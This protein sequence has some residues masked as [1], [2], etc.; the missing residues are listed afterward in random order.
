M[1]KKLRVFKLRDSKDEELH[2]ELEEYKKEL[3]SLR[4]AKI[5]GGTAAKLGRIRVWHNF[6]W[7]NIFIMFCVLAC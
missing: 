7:L 1:S 4:I 2:K 3:S 6:A 5:A